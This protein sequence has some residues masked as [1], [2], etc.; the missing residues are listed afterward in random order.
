MQD[1]YQKNRCRIAEIMQSGAVR[2]AVLFA[3]MR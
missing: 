1:M 2:S 3:W